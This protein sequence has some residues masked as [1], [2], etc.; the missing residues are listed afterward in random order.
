MMERSTGKTMD[1]YIEFFSVPD[2]MAWL[3]V[4][5]SRPQHFN[6][7]GDRLLEVELSSQEDLMKELFPK[8][9]CVTWRPANGKGP[10]V[11][12]TSE[13]FDSGFKGFVSQEEL[14]GLVRHA[15]QPHRVSTY[16]ALPFK[17]SSP[18]SISSAARSVDLT[19][20]LHAPSGKHAER[21]LVW[22]DARTLHA[23][24]GGR[25]ID[26]SVAVYIHPEMPFA[27]LH[28]ND[29]HSRQ[30]SVARHD[31]LH[32]RYAQRTLRRLPRSHQ[33]PHVLPP[34]YGLLQ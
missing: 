24:R 1:C 4:I 6:K 20:R 30:V 26:L 9:R 29:I 33:D 2:A 10:E 21:N 15:E 16:Y 27:P 32:H 19:P 17:K 3:S 28:H 25:P 31:T 11:L 12:E 5:L 13:A 8:A 34:S 23:S 18:P 14:G 7:I 22:K